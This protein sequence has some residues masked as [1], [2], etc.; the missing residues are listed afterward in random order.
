MF[1]FCKNLNRAANEKCAEALKTYSILLKYVPEPKQGENF[2]TGGI[3]DLMRIK[4]GEFRKRDMRPISN[5]SAK[6]N[7]LKDKL[8]TKVDENR[9]NELIKDKNRV[10]LVEDLIDNEIE[11]T[12]IINII[13]EPNTVLSESEVRINSEIFRVL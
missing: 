1:A 11:P 3:I 8:K 2:Q 10:K 5:L 13:T 7:E 9:L 6:Q 4:Q 12:E